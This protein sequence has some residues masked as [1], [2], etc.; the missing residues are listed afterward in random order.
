MKQITRVVLVFL[1]GLGCISCGEQ[2]E[3]KVTE[4][5]PAIDAAITSRSD[6]SETSSAEPESETVEEPLSIPDKPLSEDGPWLIIHSSQGLFALNPDGSG[7]TQFS[8]SIAELSDTEQI[9]AAPRGGYIA[10]HETSWD[11]DDTTIHIIAFP[12]LELVAEIPLF[13]YG[14]EPDWNAE[15]AIQEY[16]SM[17]FSPDGSLLAFMGV[18]EGPTSDLYQYSMDS[19]AILQLTSGRTQGYQPV[20][21]PDGKYILHTGADGFG[22]GAGFETKGIWTAQADTDNVKTLYTP[23]PN[24][25]EMIVGWVNDET[26]VVYSWSQPCG[27]GN[28]RTY[29]VESKQSTILW[30][31]SFQDIDMDPLS[32]TIVLI[33]DGGECAPEGG[34]GTYFIPVFGGDSQKISAKTGPVVVWSP[35]GENFIISGGSFEEWALGVNT[36]G[37]VTEIN[38]PSDSFY[39]PVLSPRSNYL[40]WSGKSPH[41]GTIDNSIPTIPFFNESIQNAVWTLDG[42]AII[43]IA[44][45]GLYIAHQPDF[46]AILISPDF[47]LQYT[48]DYME[49]L[50]P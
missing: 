30:S 21:S 22:T 11:E 42:Q 47:K 13:T 43:F 50:N 20:W 18:I 41:I 46:K 45:S 37:Q 33:S 19:K 17:V 9:T 6:S 7:L 28:L 32:G 16:Q 8:Q 39:L 44:D 3:S 38:R 4:E 29:N 5:S 2:P 34:E 15:R 48:D 40:F 35:A 14:D 10:Y 1:V 36:F 49:W 27:S 31:E 12:S 26:F 24:A 23:T 25:A